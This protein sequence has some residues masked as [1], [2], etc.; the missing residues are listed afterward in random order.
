[1]Q[2]FAEQIGEKALKNR[3]KASTVQR[4]IEQTMDDF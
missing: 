1:M 3:H 2:L 4:E